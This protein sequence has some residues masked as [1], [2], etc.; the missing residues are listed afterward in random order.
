MVV[1]HEEEGEIEAAQALH[2]NEIWK[3][4]VLAPF[5]NRINNGTYTF[6]GQTHHLP[7]NEHTHLRRHA[8]H[9]FLASKTMKLVAHEADDTRATVT[10]S[11]L[12]GDDEGYPFPVEVNV[13][14]QL[15]H[16]HLTVRITATNRALDGREAPF[17]VGWH[18]YFRVDDAARAKAN[19]NPNPNPNPNWMLHAPR[20]SWIIL[21]VG[22][23][24]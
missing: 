8:I 2:T 6:D 23:T 17:F 18:P 4:A 13:T 7:T 15:D 24:L 10:L 9:G 21:A 12:F 19:P 20:W 5:A 14:Y 1:G 16:S 22:S 3:G 11:H